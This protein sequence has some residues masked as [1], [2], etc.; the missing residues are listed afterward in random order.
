ML[1]LAD[2]ISACGESF[3]QPTRHDEISTAK[4]AAAA[5][6]FMFRSLAEKTRIDTALEIT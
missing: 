1:V 6:F 5:L 2:A 4:V 3:P